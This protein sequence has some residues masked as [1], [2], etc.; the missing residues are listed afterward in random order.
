MSKTNNRPTREQLEKLYGKA[1]MIHE[2]LKINGYKKCKAKYKGMG[3]FAQEAH[4]IHALTN[5]VRGNL[6][7][8]IGW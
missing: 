5:A 8:L 6:S 7:S 1:C 3:V 4:E 2:G